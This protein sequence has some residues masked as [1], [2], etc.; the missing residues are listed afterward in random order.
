[1][2]RNP[3]QLILGIAQGYEA[4]M[5]EP[6]VLSLQ[7]SGYR[8]RCRIFVEAADV[9]AQAYLT[10]HGIEVESFNSIYA[11]LQEASQTLRIP[12]AMRRFLEYLALRAL[13][14]LAT[15]GGARARVAYTK[16]APLHPAPLRFLFYH[17]CLTG[18]VGAGVRR[19]LLMDT[20]DTIFQRDP[21]DYPV[22]DGGLVVSFE[23]APW[24]IGRC[25]F[26]REWIRGVYGDK[27]VRTLAARGVYNSGAILGDAAALIV[28]IRVMIG[29][30]A[31]AA[32]RRFVPGQGLDQAVHNHLLHLAPPVPFTS[33]A[34]GTAPVVHLSRREEEQLVFSPDGFLLNNDGEIVHIVHQWVRYPDAFASA[35]A[36]LRASA[37]P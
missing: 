34:N 11:R 23:E 26:N 14:P 22:P 36:K 16:I 27:E 35:V 2:D 5:L 3:E 18:P 25:D 13:A 28:Y 30:I 31:R 24:S 20:R 29:E 8:G 9:E 12:H 4:R 1:M 32:G 21:F 19:V 37:T 33:L 6:F 15:H 10:A 17:A 7:R